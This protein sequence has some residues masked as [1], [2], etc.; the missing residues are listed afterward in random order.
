MR[1]DFFI[2]LLCFSNL[3]LIFGVNGAILNGRFILV[4]QMSYMIA[5][6]TLGVK[7]SY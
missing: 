7:S 6:T 5:L 1:H 3:Q 2:Y 4:R